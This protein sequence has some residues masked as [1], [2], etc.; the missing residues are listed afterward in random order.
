MELFCMDYTVDVTDC[1][2]PNSNE[3]DITA[4]RPAE[5]DW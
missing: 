3:S 4:N 5:N 1:H 2:G